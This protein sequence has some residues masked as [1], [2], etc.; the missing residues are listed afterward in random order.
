[1]KK[2]F[3]LIILAVLFTA[4]AVS[5]ENDTPQTGDFEKSLD[6]NISKILDA[7]SEKIEQTRDEMRQMY[8]LKLL[9]KTVLAGLGMLIIAYFLLNGA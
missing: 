5:A 6:E 7:A 2:I 1:M 9:A 3:F 4:L 8:L